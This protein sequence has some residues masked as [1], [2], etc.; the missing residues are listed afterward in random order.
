M[1]FFFWDI[2]WIIFSG[3]ACSLLWNCLFW[4]ASFWTTFLLSDYC[5]GFFCAYS[6]CVYVTQVMNTPW[7][8]LWSYLKKKKTTFCTPSVIDT[9]KSAIELLSC[10]VVCIHVGDCVLP[11]SYPVMLHKVFCQQNKEASSVS[12]LKAAGVAWWI[13]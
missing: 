7:S 5:R 3:T 6:T 10:A 8:R 11:I 12:L 9:C 1:Y 4:M 13:K 2:R